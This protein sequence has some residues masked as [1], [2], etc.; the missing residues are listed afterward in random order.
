LEYDLVGPTLPALKVLLDNPPSI[1]DGS[2]ESSYAK[3]I[4]GLT[5]CCLQNIDETRYASLHPYQ[6][7]TDYFRTL[8]RS[9]RPFPLRP[10]LSNRSGPIASLKAKNNM[11]AAV[12]VLTTM[13]NTMKLSRALVEQCCYLISQ[14]LSEPSEVCHLLHSLWLCPIIILC[15]A[16]YPPDTASVVF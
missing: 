5:S 4:H 14:R 3:V 16:S 15:S 9:Y 13:P 8:H 12:L 2:A 7:K 11:L 6:W 10:K 1:A